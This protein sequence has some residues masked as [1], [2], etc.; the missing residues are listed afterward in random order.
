[1]SELLLARR[2]L[3]ELLLDSADV[4]LLSFHVAA[5]LARNGPTGPPPPPDLAPAL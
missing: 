5:A 1:M 4:Q 2:T 3:G